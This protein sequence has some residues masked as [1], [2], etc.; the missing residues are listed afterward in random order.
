MDKNKMKNNTIKYKIRLPKTLSYQK[1]RANRRDKLN[2]I[3][4]TYHLLEYLKDHQDILGE[5]RQ[6]RCSNLE[7]NQRK[8]RHKP[9]NQ[10]HLLF[11]NKPH[12]L[13]PLISKLHKS[14]P[15]KMKP[16]KSKLLKSNHLKLNIIKFT[17]ILPK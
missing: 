1:I 9:I 14:K 4:N 12:S 13:K 5:M 6:S 2:L 15:N 3:M 17:R 8:I 7:A 11:R 16:H 10:S